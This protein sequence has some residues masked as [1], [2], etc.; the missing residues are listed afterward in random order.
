M[1]TIE[2][3]KYLKLNVDLEGT[4]TIATKGLLWEFKDVFMW[5]YKKFRK[6]PPHV[7]EHKIKL[8]T[9]IPPSHQTR[10][11]MNPNYATIVKQ[12]LDKL[13]VVSF[14]ELVLGS[15]LVITDCGS[16]QIKRQI[17]HMHWFLELEHHHKE[18]PI[19]ITFH[20]WGFG[21]GSGSWSVFIFGWFF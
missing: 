16:T 6:I 5:N 7:M 2:N 12:D 14:I 17:A 8:N 20:Q 15:N 13:L 11:H 18:I 1:G 3:L 10:Y 9:T 21:Q 19:P 4:I